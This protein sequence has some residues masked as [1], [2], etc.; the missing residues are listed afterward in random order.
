ML[1]LSSFTNMTLSADQNSVQAGP[2]LNWY[3][4]YSF[5]EPYGRV[6]IGGRLKTIGIAGLTIG[7]GIS[8][9]TSKYGF[10]MDNVLAYDVVIA[11]GHV[12]TAS[13]TSNADL[14]WAMKVSLSL[15]QSAVLR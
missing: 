2:A 9:F 4:M 10:G 13:A 12:V 14:F 11:S 15:Y 7:G 3:Q 1:A 8:Y 5:L 6:V